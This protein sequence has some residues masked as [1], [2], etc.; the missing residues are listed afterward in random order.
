MIFHTKN[1]GL[2]HTVLFTPNAPSPLF[3]SNLTESENVKISRLL[4]LRYEIKKKYCS[5]NPPPTF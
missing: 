5:L 1:A 3:R 2:W 4:I